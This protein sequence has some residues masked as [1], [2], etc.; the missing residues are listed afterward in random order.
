MHTGIFRKLLVLCKE[1]N[2]TK[3]QRTFGDMP[4][5]EIDESSASHLQIT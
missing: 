5:D 1:S 4:D 2:Q 3:V